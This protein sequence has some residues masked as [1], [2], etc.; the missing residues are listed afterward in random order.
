MD[1]RDF[2][3]DEATH[4]DIIAVADRSRHG[5]YLATLWMRPPAASNGL[6]GYRLSKRRDWPLRGLQDNA[7]L[8][9][10]GEGLVCGHRHEM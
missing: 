5:K 8:A 6:S 10:E 1:K 3:L 4:E 9:N 2:A 7:A